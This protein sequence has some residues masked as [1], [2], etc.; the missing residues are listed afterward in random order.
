MDIK[1][2]RQ[3]IYS[4]GRKCGLVEDGDKRDNLHSFVF[5]LTA[6]TS[7]SDLDD[8]QADIVIKQLR[9][10]LKAITPDVKAYISRGQSAKIFQLMYELA[11]IS[12]SDVPI[13]DRLCGVIQRELGIKVD[14]SKDIF[15][16][17]SAAQGSRLIDAIKRYIRA[18]KRK[19]ERA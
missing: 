3:H 7:I 9:R 18:A 8:A 2:K 14:P 17:F 13:R 6:R 12:P 16:G 1:Q 5:Q 4:L 10:N 11:E 15:R 19:A